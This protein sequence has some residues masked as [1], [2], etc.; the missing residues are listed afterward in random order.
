MRGSELLEV[1]E[2]LGEL[3]GYKRPLFCSELARALRLGGRDPGATVHTWERQDR[4]LSGPAQVAILMFL[5]GAKPPDPDDAI[6]KY[7]Y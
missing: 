3:W 6:R 4:V 5:A 2:R 1:R 7:R